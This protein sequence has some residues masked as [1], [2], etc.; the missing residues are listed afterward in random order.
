MWL[1]RIKEVEHRQN[2]RVTALPYIGNITEEHILKL[3]LE[4]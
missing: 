3:S 1:G 4:D 2:V